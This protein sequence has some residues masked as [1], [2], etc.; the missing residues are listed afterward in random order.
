MH[1]ERYDAVASTRQRGLRSAIP[2]VTDLPS[3]QMKTAAPERT[4]PFQKTLPPGQ[5]GCLSTMKTIDG[6]VT[7][8]ALLPETE[9]GNTNAVTALPA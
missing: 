4:P 8:G 1:R 6:A 9:R 5:R 2:S 3:G 7:F